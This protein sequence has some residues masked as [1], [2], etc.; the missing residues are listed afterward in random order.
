M[1]P[2]SRSLAPVC[3]GLYL[4]MSA[5]LFF[6]IR[7]QVH[8]HFNYTL[9]DAYIHLALAE[10]IAH[11]NYGINAGESSSPSSSAVWPL[12]L[13]PF[14]GKSW[15]VYLPLVWNLLFGAIAAWLIGMMMDRWPNRSADDSTDLWP[16]VITAALLIMVANLVGLT[17]VGMEHVLQVLLAISCAFAVTE[18]LSGRPIPTWCL[19]AAV[20][21]PM[22]R[23][24]N[25][26]ITFG[27]SILL[28]GLRR[29]RAAIAI[30]VLAILPLIGFSFF[31]HSLGL[32]FL[33]ISVLV[34]GGASDPHVSRAMTI[35]R[36]FKSA[37]RQAIMSSERWPMVIMLAI[38]C[39]LAWKE[40]DRVR[41]YSFAGVA[42]V[43]G[44]QLL[45][46]RF[47]WFHRYEIYALAFAV[48][49]FM[50]VLAE[51]PRFMFG[52]FVMGLC[53][54]GGMSISVFLFS[55]QAAGDIYDQQYQMHRFI[56][57]FYRG[58]FAVN[59]LGFVSYQKPSDDVVVDLWG[60]GSPEA[61]S[62]T[63]KD[64]PWLRQITQRRAVSLVMIYP[65]WYKSIPEEWTPLGKMCLLSDPVVLTNQCVVFYSTTPAAR[66][67]IWNSLQRFAP[68]LPQGDKFIFLFRE[69]S[70]ELP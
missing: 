17:F 26:A 67:K 21:G 33:P 65:N 8:G 55:T 39:R 29:R 12:L 32:P 6:A 9:D 42:T 41:R 7:H 38:F 58:T 10:N 56:Q 23:Y 22:V 1:S 35:I 44:L 25:L 3:V 37:A 43:V 50:H 48:L 47:G 27:I 70:Y 28:I 2:A 16:Q 13:I 14:V 40:S 36:I 54:L 46:G 57:D 53:F 69:G 20:I 4:L 63:V 19:A 45:T 18:A 5:L 30:L 64:A 66:E 68:T 51:R 24:E 15:H 49:V 61:A 52:Y 62:Q 11:G 31:L 60:L 59:D 34:K